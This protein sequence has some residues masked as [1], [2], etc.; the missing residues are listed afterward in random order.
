MVH[1]KLSQSGEW[2]IYHIRSLASLRSTACH[3]RGKAP[4]VAY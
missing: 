1:G 2:G 4:N 3:E